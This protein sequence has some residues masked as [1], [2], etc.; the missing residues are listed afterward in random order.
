MV[1]GLKA[2]TPIIT[3]IAD[4][5]EAHGTPKVLE[6]YANGT[7]DFTQYSLQNQTNGNATWGT[8]FDLSPLGTV[9]D[10][11]VYVFSEGSGSNANVGIFAQNFPSATNVLDASSSSV[12]S[13]NGDDRVRIINTSTTAVIDMYGVEGTDGTGTNWEYKDG[14][15]KRN[16]GTGPDPVFVEANWEFHNG[17][18]NG[19]GAVQDGTTFESIIGIGTFTPPTS[20]TPTLTISSPTAGQI[21]S[22]ETTDV[23]VVFTVLNFNVA[24]SGGD[25][26]IKYSVDAGSSVDKYDTNPIQL[27]GLSRAS[28]TIDMELVDNSGNSLTPP[29]TASVTFGI[30]D[31]IQVADLAAL[32]ASAVD[33]YYEVTGESYVIGG[34]QVGNSVQGFLQDNTAG[35]MV[36]DN[37]QIVTIQ[38]NPFDGVTGLKGQLVEYHGV[39][40]LKP[41]ANLSM[42]GNN[43]PIAFQVITADE[44]NNNHENYESEL[45]QILGGT[46]ANTGSHTETEFVQ[47]HNYDLTDASNTTKLRCFF[48]DLVGTT[49]P[50]GSVDVAGIGGEYNGTAQIYPRGGFD[51]TPT[52]SISNN[53]IEGLNIYP[54]PVNDGKIYVTTPSNNEKQVVVYDMTGKQVV[55]TNVYNNQAISVSTLKSGVYLIKVVE[56]NKVSTQKL[57]IQ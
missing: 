36:Y 30:A 18:L 12:L 7:V 15:A 52:N 44:F 16:N 42:T 21:Y 38:P 29:V 57:M 51:I 37:Q 49:I 3:M 23:D 56:D 47:N 26:Y 28:H 53:N 39:L 34:Q 43:H 40:E 2:Q 48:H 50:S 9:T 11:F 54:N 17:E 10:G 45:I 13:I 27:Q 35:I 8:A 41:T 20:S 55:N 5:D 25:G 24:Q 33:G 14:Y 46:I 31:Y 19:H 22:P 4:G 6:I 1:F 32:R